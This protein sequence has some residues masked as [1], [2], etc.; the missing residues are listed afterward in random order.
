MIA[1]NNIF[2]IRKGSKWLGMT[3][4][5]KGFVEFD[6]REHAMRAWLLLMRTYRRRYGCKTIRQI[7]ARYAPPTENDTAG[8]IRYCCKIALHEPDQELLFDSDYCLLGMAM[9]KMETGIELSISELYKIMK[10]YDIKIV[11]YEK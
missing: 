11:E 3:G 5:R 8:Y 1:K 10:K 4:E 2:N 7:V 9:A 6:N